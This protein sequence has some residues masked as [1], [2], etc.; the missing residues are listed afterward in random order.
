MIEIKNLSKI[1]LLPP[2]SDTVILKNISLRLPEGKITALFAPGHSGKS[3]LLKIV[4]GLESPDSG[5][6]INKNRGKIIF[7]P[8]APSSFPWLSV[9][10]NIKLG[11]TNSNE[12]DITTIIHLVGLEGYESFYPANKSIGFR[13]RI[14]LARSLAHNPSVILIDESFRMMDD[15][16]RMESY[17]LLRRINSERGTTFFIATAN[18][19]EAI[20]LS[21]KIYLM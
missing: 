9:S 20:F 6:I 4:S 19:P 5:D 7:L 11:L 2:G 15:R 17:N 3:L 21:D 10:D 1:Y 8:S 12:T 14:A 16:T 18:L 13:F